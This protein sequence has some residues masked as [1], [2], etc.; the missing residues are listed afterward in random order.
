MDTS[1]IQKLRRFSLSIGL[2][3]FTYSVA[4]IQLDTP[5]KIEPLGIPLVIQNP[6]LIGYALVLASL[7]A[8]IRYLYYAVLIGPSP[9]TIR[10]RL[11]EGQLPDLR[12]SFSD[13]GHN[14]HEDFSLEFNKWFP[15]VGK[16]KAS[17]RILA[18]GEVEELNIPRI[19]RLFCFLEDIDYYSPIWVNIIAVSSYIIFN[20][21]L[22]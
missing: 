14:F 19:V 8:S 9:R 20:S 12:R 21:H 13:A 15:R 22:L 17:C 6:Y 3:T 10:K 7:Y 1:L 16:Q 5:A 4:G 11:I 2:I 18:R